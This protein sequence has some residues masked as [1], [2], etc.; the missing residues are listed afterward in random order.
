M[1]EKREKFVID[2]RNKIIDL[3]LSRA[4]DKVE[5]IN[6]LLS[7]NQTISFLPRRLASKRGSWC[8][9][10][11]YGNWYSKLVSQTS[12]FLLKIV[13]SLSIC[14]KMMNWWIL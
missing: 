7:N 3:K 14:D 10:G 8:Q 12:V 2:D 11:L 13:K 5:L 1:K 4:R 9:E 6:H